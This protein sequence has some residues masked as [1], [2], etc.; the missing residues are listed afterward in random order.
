MVGARHFEHGARHGFGKYQWI[1]GEVYQGEWA[2]DRP[3]GIGVWS[4][5][6]RFFHGG[7][8]RGVPHGPGAYVDQVT[9]EATYAEFSLGTSADGRLVLPELLLDA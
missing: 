7:W 3:H 2:H 4:S 1:D 5:D 8:R 9:K 6:D